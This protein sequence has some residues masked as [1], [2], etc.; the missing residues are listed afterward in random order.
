VQQ[1]ERQHGAASEENPYHG[2][3][4]RAIYH[5]TAVAHLGEELVRNGELICKQTRNM[6][7][8]RFVRTD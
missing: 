6:N 8:H 5:V 4:E 7:T 3:E 1:S 2:V